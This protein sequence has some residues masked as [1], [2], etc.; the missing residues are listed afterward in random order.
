MLQPMR[1]LAVLLFIAGAAAA[2]VQLGRMRTIA[3]G[4]VVGAD[5]LDLLRARGVAAMSCDRDI[6]IGVDGAAFICVATLG[7]GATQTAAY[8]MDRAGNF[9]WKLLHTTDATDATDA[10]R[11]RIPPSGDPWAN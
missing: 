2:A 5:L 9:R 11:R 4:R 1:T 6:P 3:D 7:N 10:P 8:Q